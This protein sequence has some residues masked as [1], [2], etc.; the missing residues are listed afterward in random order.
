MVDSHD[1]QIVPDLIA[2]TISSVRNT[3][4]ADSCPDR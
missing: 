4:N 2:R 3:V 1:L